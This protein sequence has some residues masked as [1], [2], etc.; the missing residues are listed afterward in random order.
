MRGAENFETVGEA[1]SRPIARQAGLADEVYDAIFSQL[2]ALKI[3][4][5][6]RAPMSS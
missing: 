2:M 4:P 6:S 5:G 3:A 1:G